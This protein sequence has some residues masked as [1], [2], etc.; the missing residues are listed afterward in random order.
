MVEYEEPYTVEL[1][2]KQE[3]IRTVKNNRKLKPWTLLAEI[4]AEHK[5]LKEMILSYELT[6]D[7]DGYIVFPY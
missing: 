3:I 7:A 4:N 5:D 2:D 1:D 6:I